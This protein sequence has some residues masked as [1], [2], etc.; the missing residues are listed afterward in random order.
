MEIARL[1]EL[2]VYSVRGHIKSL[3]RKLGVHSQLQAVVA[4]A[5]R[6]I[7]DVLGGPTPSRGN[8]RGSRQ[9]PIPAVG[10]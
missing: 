1:L 7:V 8:P 4:A 6:G 10:A 3:M 9:W 2:S 5:R